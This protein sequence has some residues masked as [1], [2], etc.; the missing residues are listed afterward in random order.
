MGI[1]L[2][3]NCNHQ[4]SSPNLWKSRNLVGHTIAPDEITVLTKQPLWNFYNLSGYFTS[5]L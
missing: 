5:L 2:N 3:E 4:L 1:I